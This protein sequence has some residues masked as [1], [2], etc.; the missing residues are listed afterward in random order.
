MLENNA[1]TVPKRGTISTGGHDDG[2]S[3]A[4]TVG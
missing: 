1:K 3:K 4:P 2:T